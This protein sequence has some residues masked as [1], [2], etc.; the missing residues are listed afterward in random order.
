MPDGRLLTKRSFR[1][2]SENKSYENDKN[3][4]ENN[5]K[6][7][8]GGRKIVKKLYEKKLRKIKMK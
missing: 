7:G 8:I 6:A 2:T 5:D 3:L 1:K 4:Y